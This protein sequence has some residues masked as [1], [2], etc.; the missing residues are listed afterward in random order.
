MYNGK[1]DGEWKFYYA[2]NIL[3][4]RGTYKQG[5]QDGIFTV[6]HDNSQ[7]LY[8]G[9]YSKGKKEGQFDFYHKDGTIN[10]HKTGTYK[11]GNKISD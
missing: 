11:N 8:Q 6:Y 10:E 4:A 9:N 5:K 3:K 7:I 1:K 2:E